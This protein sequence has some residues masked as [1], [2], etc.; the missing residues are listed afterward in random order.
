[1]VRSPE[2]ATETEVG[3]LTLL[4][5]ASAKGLQIPT[6]HVSETGDE[7]DRPQ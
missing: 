1:M 3:S 6:G 5:S 2:P 7:P 4:A